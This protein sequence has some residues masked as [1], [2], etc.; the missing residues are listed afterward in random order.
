MHTDLEA[1][2]RGEI[3]A[4]MARQGVT[5]GTLAASTDKH[6]Q[7]VGRILAGRSPMTFAFA[8]RV[9]ATLGLSLSAMLD[10]AS[11]RTEG[12]A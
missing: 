10:R 9:A 2:L 5:I 3:R 1:A 11:A 8:D 12:A 6:A 4:E 7:T